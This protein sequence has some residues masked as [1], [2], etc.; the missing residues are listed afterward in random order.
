MSYACVVQ[1]LKTL[2]TDVTEREKMS[3]YFINLFTI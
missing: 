1:Y 3:V 2:S